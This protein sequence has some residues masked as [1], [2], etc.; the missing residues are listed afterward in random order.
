[1]FIQH[2]ELCHFVIAIST[3]H[4]SEERTAMTLHVNPN[5][6][7][8]LL[9]ICHLS[10]PV[11]E[12]WLCTEQVLHLTPQWVYSWKQRV[13]KEE[14]EREWGSKEERGEI[15]IV[16]EKWKKG[17][18]TGREEECSERTS[19]RSVERKGEAAEQTLHERFSYNTW[20]CSSVKNF[21]SP[22]S[23]QHSSGLQLHFI[24]LLTTQG[25]TVNQ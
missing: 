13:R 11:F 20:G 21:I 5:S 8:L 6:L 22:P 14:R 7:T 23:S 15:E 17:K 9:L 2:Y 1:M 18:A 3:V 16:R 24:H 12:V 25:C 10:L 4:S 19:L